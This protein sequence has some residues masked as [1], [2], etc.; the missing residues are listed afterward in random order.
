MSASFFR[1]LEIGLI[2]WNDVGKPANRGRCV[3]ITKFSPIPNAI[4][5]DNYFSRLTRKIE[6]GTETGTGKKRWQEAFL[7]PAAR[8]TLFEKT[9]PLDPPQKLFI[10]RSPM[11]GGYSNK[12]AKSSSPKSTVSK[13]DGVK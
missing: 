2:G 11:P 12:A 7:P 4:I 9:A 13:S 1:N 8:G 6:K 10:N 3:R 5:S